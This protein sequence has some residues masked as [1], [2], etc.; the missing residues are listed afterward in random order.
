MINKKARSHLFKLTA[1]AV[2]VAMG[3]ALS[4]LTVNIPIGGLIAKQ[5]SIWLVTIYIVAMLF[6]PLYGMA[7]GFLCDLFST[8]LNPS[9]GGYNPAFAVAHVVGHGL[10]LFAAAGREKPETESKDE[11]KR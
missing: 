2:L 9:G 11:G 5:I 6:G 1:T 3:T 8:L 7:A 10:R 4:F